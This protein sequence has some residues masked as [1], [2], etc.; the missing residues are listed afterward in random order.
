MWLAAIREAYSK[1][2]LSGS[3]GYSYSST[4]SR[5]SMALAFSSC[6]DSDN[7]RYSGTASIVVAPGGIKR[8]LYDWDYS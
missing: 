2:A 1:G 3:S 7:N 4:R 6:M 5:S 8:W